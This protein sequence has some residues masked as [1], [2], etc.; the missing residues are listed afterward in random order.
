GV[1]LAGGPGSDSLA[2]GGDE[3]I[4]FGGAGDDTLDGAGGNDILIDGA[5]AD[6]LRGGAGA[7]VFILH[8]DGALDRIADFDIAQDRLDLSDWL[9]LN[10]LAQIAITPT[11][12]G[13]VLRYGSEVLEIVTHDGSSLLPGQFTNATILNLPRPAVELVHRE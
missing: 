10:S 3:D 6:L 12:D 5:G 8:A 4:L 7:D 2:G 13:A 9:L 1:T 11:V